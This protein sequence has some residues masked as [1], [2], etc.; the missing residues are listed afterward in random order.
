MYNNLQITYGQP[1]SSQPQIVAGA[2]SGSEGGGPNIPN[3]RLSFITAPDQTTFEKL[4]VQG[5]VG[6]K[7][8]TGEG[9]KEILVKSKLSAETLAQ[10]WKLSNLTKNNYLTFPEFALAMYL[11]NLKLKKQDLPNTIPDNIRN[12]VMGVIEQI[13]VIEQELQKLHQKQQLQQ[14]APQIQRTISPSHNQMMSHPQ[15]QQYTG[16]QVGPNIVQYSSNPSGIQNSSM[17]S[18]MMP[19]MMPFTQRMLPQQNPPQQ[20]STTGIVGN[21]E[22]PWAVTPEEKIQ[23][24]EIF[25]QWDS[26]GFGYLTGEK[27]KEILSQSGLPQSD[28]MQIWELSDP[29]NNGKLNQD[30]F[31]VAMHLIYRK[32]N[33]YDVPT[34]LPPELVPPSSR[35]LSESVNMIKNMLKSDSIHNSSIGLGTHTSGANYAKSRSF[36]ATPTINRNDATGYK[37]TDDENVYV[38]SSRYRVPSVP[39]SQNTSSYSSLSKSSSISSVSENIGEDRSSK[40]SE[41]KKQIHEKQIML[42]AYSYT[43]DTAPIS[44]NSSYSSDDVYEL[45]NKIKNIQREINEKERSNPEW[46]NREFTRNSE[47][48]GSLL[49]QHKNLDDELNNMLVTIVPELISKIRETSNK[50]PDSK[51]ELFKLREG[52]GGGSDLNIIGTG[53]GGEITE[54]DRIKAK[55][56]AMIQARMAA[57]TGK[58]VNFGGGGSSSSINPRLLEEETD[59]INSEKAEREFKVAEIERS[60]SKL[61]DSVIKASREREEIEDKYRKIERNK[62]DRESEMRKWEDGIGVD[63]DVSR[64]IQDLK[65]DS[66]SSSRYDYNSD[67]YSSSRDVSYN[68][69][70]STSSTSSSVYTSVSNTTNTPPSSLSKSKSPEEREAFIKA[71]AERR[72]Q[73]KLKALGVK[74]TSYSKSSPSSDPDSPTI[75]D[76]LAR[77]KAEAAERKARAEREAEERERIRTERL[78]AEKQKKAEQDAEKLRKMEEFEKKEEERRNQ[79]LA[80]AKELEKAKDR[81]AREKEAAMREKELELERKRVE[82]AEKEKKLE[83]ERSARIKREE[84]ERAAEEERRRIEQ[85]ALVE[86]AKAAREKAKKMEEEAKQ[87]EETAK[88]EAERIKT[89]REDST[90]SVKSFDSGSQTPTFVDSSSNNPFLNLSSQ[91]RKVVDANENDTIESTNPFFKFTSGAAAQSNVQSSQNDKQD[92]DDDWNVVNNEE[93]SDDEFPPGNTKQLASKLFGSGYSFEPPNFESVK[94]TPP[95]SNSTPPPSKVPTSNV[96]AKSNSI[97]IPPPLPSNSN[98][99]PVPPPLPNSND[100]PIPP[101]LPNSN[102]IP[103]P[104]PL[105]NSNDVPIPP[106]LPNSNDVPIPPPLPSNSSVPPAPPLPTTSTVPPPPPQPQQPL[107]SGN[108]SQSLPLP[109]GSRNALLSQ[110]QQGAKLKPTKTNDRSSPLVGGKTNDSNSST[111]NSSGGVSQPAAGM[112]GLSGLGALFAGG[113]PKLKNRGGVETGSSPTENVA[114]KSSPPTRQKTMGRRVSTDWFGNLSSDQLAGEET[115]KPQSIKT[116]TPVNEGNNILGQSVTSPTSISTDNDIDYSQEFRVKSLFN[117]PG[118]GGA[119]DLKFDAGIVFVAHPSKN[120]NNAEWWH[121]SIEETGSKGWFPKNFVEIYKE[122]KEICKAKA[123]YDYK[124]QNSTELDI[125]SGNIV[126]ILDKSLN[127]WWKAEFEGSKGY[128]PA[129]YVEEITSSSVLNKTS[130]DESNESDGSEDKTDEDNSSQDESSKDGSISKYHNITEIDNNTTQENLIESS[131]KKITKILPI[132]IPKVNIQGVNSPTTSSFK[133]PTLKV[134]INTLTPGKLTRKPSLEVARSPSPTRLFGASPIMSIPWMQL[135]DPHKDH[136]NTHLGVSP[137]NHSQIASRPESPVSPGQGPSVVSWTSIMD[138]ETIKG[139]TKEDRKRQEAIF[140]LISTEQSY[141][142][143]L[144]MIIEVF[145]GPLQNILIEDELK[146]IFSNIEDILLCNTA[147]LSDLEQRQKDDK[148]FVKNVGDILLK[149]SDDL[150]CYEIYCGKQLNASKFLQ[151]KRNVNKTFSEFLKKAQ[152]DPQCG[153]LDLSSFLLKPMQRI[154]RYPLLIRQILH[155]TNKNDSDQEDLMKA[156]HKAETILEST[157]EAAREQE[158]KLKLTEISKL[159]DL[160]D[161]EEKLDLTST[162]RSVGKRQFILEGALKKAKSGRNLYGYLFNDLLLLTQ[163]NKKSV[164][165]GYQYALYKPPILL[166]EIVVKRGQD[167]TFQ[168]LHIGD[169]IN[170]KAI[171]I[172]AKQQWVN[173]LETANGYCLEVEN[174]KRK[175]EN[176]TPINSIGTLKVTVYEAVIPIDANEKNSVNTYCQVQLN[177]Q[178][179]KTKNVKAD[180]FPHWNQYLMFSVTTLEDTL[181]LSVYQYDKYSED[182]YLGKAEIKLHF[183]EHYAGNETDKIKLQLQEVEPGRPFGSISVYLNYKPF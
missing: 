80:E 153:S 53:P 26:Q 36:N 138:P 59:R 1:P 140:E 118:T 69:R 58:S 150:V 23:Y 143:D 2:T 21:A 48:L 82:A 116:E 147:I 70:S 98:S 115:P 89:K 161:L 61:Q 94:T 103:I 128:V 6:G 119:D 34:T 102:D 158:N 105:P 181:K 178:I 172:S 162:T 28:L 167:E 180:I 155:Y 146:I 110:I 127:D 45:K 183:L 22:I 169:V 10:I 65:R 92:D 11:T 163:H 109:S 121:G 149:H 52:S 27:A 74:K 14:Q 60:I 41:L 96:T 4:Y 117:Y 113:V 171:S 95:Q 107:S 106:P 54:S 88:R 101:P 76:R 78:L 168:I 93:S 142:R 75:S 43:A 40:I 136:D 66:S 42:E 97:P 131:S 19:S 33:G 46:L 112:G 81:K 15:Q 86:N 132:D 135:G 30:E 179:F 72:M 139:I 84:E 160:E 38:S 62:R 182:E 12:E 56:Q 104:P 18:G 164:A 29:N 156:L 120:P 16:M 141:L 44:Y 133:R 122:E 8:L 134:N 83:E 51:L 144:Q 123:L 7:Y 137:P 129:N 159:V 5:C 67:T 57:I 64:F 174:Q 49:E 3:V 39:R 17:I 85:E 114:S 50:I 73:E 166:N 99:I 124:A 25:R 35:E 77:E 31:A 55:A 91:E 130:T 148:L 151:N 152:Q 145:Y 71:E 79:W 9:A 108:K 20:Y 47:E 63:D 125:K 176:L 175:K 68:R 111:Q 154:T 177:R 170:L 32:L 126:S 90:F 37:H 87:R 100:V 165:K 157:N 173:Q 24:R 13:R